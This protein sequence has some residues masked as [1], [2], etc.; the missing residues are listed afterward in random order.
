MQNNHGN[1]YPNRY[2]NDRYGHRSGD[3]MMHTEN[4]R[5]KFHIY[6][7]CFHNEMGTLTVIA[8]VQLNMTKIV[9]ILDPVCVLV[10]IKK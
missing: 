1:A 3:D 7:N 6:C 9:S 5:N 8:T 4:I 2:S 10:N